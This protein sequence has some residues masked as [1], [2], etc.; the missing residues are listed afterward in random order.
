[1]TVG[2]GDQTLWGVGRLGPILAASLAVGGRQAVDPDYKCSFCY[3]RDSHGGGRGREVGGGEEHGE[4][5]GTEGQGE[6]GLGEQPSPE[7]LREELRGVW[8]LSREAVS[9]E[10][11]RVG[12]RA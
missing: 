11:R 3:P 9:K 1:M 10:K 7:G 5:G 12:R 2:V 4:N 8:E 6:R